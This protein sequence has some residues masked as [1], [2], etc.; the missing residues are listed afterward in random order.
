[1][2][3]LRLLVLVIIATC[4]VSAGFA[5]KGAPQY[6]TG[7]L[8]VLGVD[9]FNFGYGEWL[10]C[11]FYY[12]WG[13]YTDYTPLQQ[14][15]NWYVFSDIYHNE[16]LQYIEINGRGQ[17]DIGNWHTM[18]AIGIPQQGILDVIAERAWDDPIK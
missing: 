17:D 4:L 3:T 11:T 14:A 16:G 9:Y 5:Q 2:K 1:M 6:Y 7:R 13:T 8:H 12:N 15:A 10:Y 18:Q